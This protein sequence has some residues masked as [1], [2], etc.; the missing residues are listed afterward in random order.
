MKKLSLLAAVVAVLAVAAPASAA[1]TVTISGRAYAFN[2]MDTFLAG[3]AIKVREIPGLEATTDAN[4]DYSLEVPDDTNVTPYLDPPAGYNEIDLQ[5]FHPRGEDIENANFQTPADAEYNGLAAI[6]SVP[7]DE[8]TGRPAQCAIVTTAS[9]RNVRGVDYQTFWDRTPHGVPGATSEEFPELDG[10]I[11]FNEFVIPDPTKTETSEDGGIVWTEVPAGTYRIVTSSPT[12]GF[13][14]FLAT[15]KDGRIVN[16]NPPWGAYELDPGE[17]P[18]AAGV[19]A[20]SVTGAEGRAGGKR[21]RVAV[22]VDSGEAPRVNAILRQAGRRV[23]HVRT[24]I[25]V[26]SETV[27]VPVRPRASRGAATVS[28]RLRDA[29]KDRVTTEHRV[30]LPRS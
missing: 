29:A 26:G 30:T 9:A 27:R 5:T 17:Q 20:S 25:G 13:A 21:R 12:T 7:I 24:D 19:V 10:P 11:Y 4:G 16:A 14:S 3:A 23:G 15:C 18:L 6:L 2:H 22:T 8:E 28:I 1:D